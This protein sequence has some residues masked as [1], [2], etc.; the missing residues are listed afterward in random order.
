MVVVLI[1]IYRM[2]Q[3]ENV[4]HWEMGKKCDDITPVRSSDTWGG[5]TR[6]LRY[7]VMRANLCKTRTKT[8]VSNK[9]LTCDVRVTLVPSKSC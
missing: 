2:N 3:R 6:Y 4:P 9:L 5:R 8:R 7:K 1:E